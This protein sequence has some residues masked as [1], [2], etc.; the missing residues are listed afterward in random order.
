MERR[1]ARMISIPNDPIINC[2]ERTGY[3]PW[4]FYRDD[5]E[6]EEE[7]EEEDADV[8]YGNETPSF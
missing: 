2:I 3:P 1:I 4:Y 5:E 7:S 8:Y 6:D